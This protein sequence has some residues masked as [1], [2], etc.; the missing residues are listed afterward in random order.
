MSRLRRRRRNSRAALAQI[1]G[2]SN[3]NARAIIRFSR[4]REARR[5]REQKV[6]PELGGTHYLSMKINEARD[7]LLGE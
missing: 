1:H 5:S 7:V 2:W 6:S 3:S 4:I